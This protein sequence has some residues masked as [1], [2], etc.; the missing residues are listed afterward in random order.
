MNQRRSLQQ[1]A[2][3]G[4]NA[5]GKREQLY[6]APF[7]PFSGTWIP[8]EAAA[9]AGGTPVRC[10]LLRAPFG[11]LVSLPAVSSGRTVFPVQCRYS[12][13]KPPCRSR[14][15]PVKKILGF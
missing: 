4:D 9:T 15:A 8:V 2:Q 10:G 12:P 7:S 6:L 3:R 13:A 1:L 14:L 5:D 11:F